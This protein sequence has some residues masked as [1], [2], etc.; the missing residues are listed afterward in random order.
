MVNIQFVGGMKLEPILENLIFSC[1]IEEPF[2]FIKIFNG[3]KWL[4]V[5][6]L[7]VLNLFSSGVSFVR[8]VEL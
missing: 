2:P 6:V 4:P 1:C 8:R 3:L 7:P 5:N